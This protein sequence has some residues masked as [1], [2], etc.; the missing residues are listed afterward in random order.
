M[1]TR[2]TIAS[3]SPCLFWTNSS[4]TSRFSHLCLFVHLSR[5]C[6]RNCSFGHTRLSLTKIPK[7]LSCCL[8]SMLQRTELFQRFSFLTE[9]KN[10]CL[11]PIPSCCVSCGFLLVEVHPAPTAGDILVSLLAFCQFTYKLAHCLCHWAQTRAG[12]IL[13]GPSLRMRLCL[14]ASWVQWFV[15]RGLQPVGPS[16]SSYPVYRVFCPQ[17][18]RETH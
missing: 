6:T 15:H 11:L 5:I 2:P 4:E 16:V 9:I 8:A 3:V 10:L 1:P 18:C 7:T 13:S 12:G 14:L 17:P